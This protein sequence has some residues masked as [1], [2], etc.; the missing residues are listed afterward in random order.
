M[1][2]DQAGFGVC[3]NLHI[4]PP[5]KYAPISDFVSCLLFLQFDIEVAI[6]GELFDLVGEF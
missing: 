4:A 6:N 2:F 1:S 3:N 5:L